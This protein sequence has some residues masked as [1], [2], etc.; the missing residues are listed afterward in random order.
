MSNISPVIH[1]TV[2]RAGRIELEDG[3][4]DGV[5]LEVSRHDLRDYP[6]NLVYQKMVLMTQSDYQALLDLSAPSTPQPLNG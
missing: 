3:L 4:V 2:V 5:V 6:L 1:G